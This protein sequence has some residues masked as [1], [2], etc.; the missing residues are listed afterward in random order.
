MTGLC[1]CK[2]PETATR[3]TIKGVSEGKK[4]TVKT[5]KKSKLCFDVI[6]CFSSLVHM[7]RKGNGADECL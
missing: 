2:G 5:T 4:Q 7:L 6:R 1:Y 3:N